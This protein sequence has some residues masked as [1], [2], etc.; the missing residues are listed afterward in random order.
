[1]RDAHRHRLGDRPAVLAGLEALTASACW[2]EP[3][4]VDIPQRPQEGG[5]T[6]P[7]QVA[8]AKRFGLP[9]QTVSRWMTKWETAALISRTRDGRRNVIRKVARLR[10]S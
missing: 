4:A 10:L 8:I 7:S 6:L 5:E 9:K 1:V 2:D 3:G